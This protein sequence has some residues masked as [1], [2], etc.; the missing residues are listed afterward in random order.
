MCRQHQAKADYDVPFRQVKPPEVSLLVSTI[1]PDYLSSGGSRRVQ[2][3]KQRTRLSSREG[4]THALTVQRH[5]SEAWKPHFC[6]HCD[7]ETALWPRLQDKSR[8]YA[9]QRVAGGIPLTGFKVTA[10]CSLVQTNFPW[11]KIPLRIERQTDERGEARVLPTLCRKHRAAATA[12]CAE[13][14]RTVFRTG[15]LQGRTPCTLSYARRG[16]SL[17]LDVSDLRA[18]LM[19][20]VLHSEGVAAQRRLIEAREETVQCDVDDLEVGRAQQWQRQLLR[21]EALLG[22]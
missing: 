19:H 1:C 8:S 15:G 10:R 18:H 22:E 13:Q 6:A 2:G 12:A 11:A 21:G 9:Q 20:P 17:V 3:W 14:C 7:T 4:Q 5:S 16:L